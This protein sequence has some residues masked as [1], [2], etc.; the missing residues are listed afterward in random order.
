M[1]LAMQLAGDLCKRGFMSKLIDGMF[2]EVLPGLHKTMDLT[3]R[4]NQALVSNI[5][6]A[7]TPQY[8][9]VD[10]NFAAELQKAFN[11][12]VPSE[13]NKTNPKHMDVS[14]K[15]EAHLVPDYSGATK[16][17]GNNVDIDIQMGRL[18]FNSG[19]F[20]LA[21]N[22]VRRHL[23]YLKNAIREGAR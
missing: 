3:Y 10:L 12:K 23:M 5:S 19:K 14:S 15:S 2:N 7:D 9:A 8:R 18:A 20:S 13:L 1:L 16:G 11:E 22:L 17:D 21:A 6:N 4:R